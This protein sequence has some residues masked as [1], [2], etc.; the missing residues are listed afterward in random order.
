MT[1]D[2]VGGDLAA[3]LRAM[4]GFRNIAVHDYRALDP[5]VLEAIVADD[6]GDLEGFA[7]AV[8]RFLVQA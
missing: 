3:R 2:V 7:D 8:R 4:A 1:D 5:A 6:L